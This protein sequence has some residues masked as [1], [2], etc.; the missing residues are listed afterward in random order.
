LKVTQLFTALCAWILVY[1]H[2]PPMGQK[3][4]H[5]GLAAVAIDIVL[6]LVNSIRED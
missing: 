1:H 4:M 5:V 3:L 2:M 6:W